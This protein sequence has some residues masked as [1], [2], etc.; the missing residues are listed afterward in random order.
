MSSSS[1]CSD[2][3]AAHAELV[4]QPAFRR[5]PVAGVEGAPLDLPRDLPVDPVIERLGASLNGMS[6]DSLTAV[7]G[8]SR[9]LVGV[10]P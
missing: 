2:G 4:A 7:V 1:A 10:G 6:A 8:V 3:G 5:E 9:I